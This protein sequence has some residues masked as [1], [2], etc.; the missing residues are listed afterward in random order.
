MK[1]EPFE[2]RGTV[3]EIIESPIPAQAL[4]L[5][6]EHGRALKQAPAPKQPPEQAP[7]SKQ[8]P[9]PKQATASRQGSVPKKA[10]VQVIPRQV[11]SSRA[12]FVPKDGDSLP[13]V[14]G[15]VPSDGCLPRFSHVARCSSAAAT[16][17]S[18][19]SNVSTSS[20][21]TTARSSDEDFAP[22]LL[23]AAPDR[24]SAT[25]KGAETPQQKTQKCKEVRMNKTLKCT[26][27][28]GRVEVDRA[29]FFSNFF[30]PSTKTK[31]KP[32]PDAISALFARVTEML[33]SHCALQM[34]DFRG[35]ENQATIRAY[36]DA[37]F[38]K[39]YVLVGKFTDEPLSFEVRG[40][41][42]PIDHVRGCATGIKRLWAGQMR[43]AKV[44]EAENNKPQKMMCRDRLA[45]RESYLE[46]NNMD[47]AGTRAMY[48]N[49]RSEYLRRNDR[50]A[51]ELIALDIIR[52]ELKVSDPFDNFVAKVTLFPAEAIFC[53]PRQLAVFLRL[54]A[55]PLR[56]SRPLIVGIDSTTQVGRRYES[57][58]EKSKPIPS[59][60]Y[61]AAVS[62][63]MMNTASNEVV[64]LVESLVLHED[65]TTVNGFLSFWL[66]RLKSTASS[67]KGKLPPTL[68]D[69]IVSDK[70]LSTLYAVSN[71]FN[72]MQLFQYVNKVYEAIRGDQGAASFVKRRL[73]LVKIC[74]AHSAHAWKRY[75]YRVLPT[76]SKSHRTVLRHMFRLVTGCTNYQFFLSVVLL[77][78]LI[79][80]NSSHRTKLM[81]TAL[82]TLVSN[83]DTMAVFEEAHDHLPPQLAVET[84]VEL[85]EVDVN[86]LNNADQQ[87][88]YKRSAF[89]ADFIKVNEVV[90]EMVNAAEE[91]EA[92]QRCETNPF[93][94]RDVVNYWL[95]VQAQYLPLITAIDWTIKFSDVPPKRVNNQF[96]EAGFAE[97]KTFIREHDGLRLGN[98][99]DR[100][101]LKT[102]E[103]TKAQLKL[104]DFGDQ[105]TLPMRPKK[106]R[107][108]AEKRLS[109]ISLWKAK[110]KPKIRGWRNAEY[111][112]AA[113]A[114]KLER[115][116][117]KPKKGQP[118]C[119]TQSQPTNVSQCQP[120]N[121]SQCQPPSQSLTL[122][123]NGVVADPHY[124]VRSL[125]TMNFYV[126]VFINRLSVTGE[127]F[128]DLR[129]IQYYLW[130][131]TVY[132]LI[133]ILVQQNRRNDVQVL[134]PSTAAA[135]FFD[136]KRTQR[137]LAAGSRDYQIDKQKSLILAPVTRNEHH[138]LVVIDTV[139]NVFYIV[140]SNASKSK[141][142]TDQQ[143]HFTA[144]VNFLQLQRIVITNDWTLPIAENMRQKDATSC[145]V[146]V[147]EHAKQILETGSTFIN[148]E[149]SATQGRLYY[150]HLLLE[151]SDNMTDRCMICM[152]DAS[153]G[154]QRCKL[155]QRFSHLACLV[156]PQRAEYCELCLLYQNR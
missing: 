120:T 155:C 58:N 93:F 24:S 88:L 46:Q 100:V 113:A 83:C 87:P 92:T 71:N 104:I 22:H 17:T 56:R 144:W 117:T 110:T 15:S 51:D 25:A 62:V 115:S 21:C 147:V 34:K 139:A 121:A 98:R 78:M 43:R 116:S 84:V 12:A 65:T 38:C 135:I 50:D 27:V 1:T 86:A 5:A 74:F 150:A 125:K 131:D 28:M 108:S 55:S 124:Y 40:S 156:Q 72:K 80:F 152:G 20:S 73:T 94:S 45:A 102:S 39:S 97:V 111:L 33:P 82:D 154:I 36:C 137:M 99:I 59:K 23:V 136:P 142:I 105:D 151:S 32:G 53:S 8:A 47:G 52:K 138:Y 133:Q 106:R 130:S 35:T 143:E 79:V 149:F 91:D 148:P 114:K 11:V 3:I 118:T 49:I 67:A 57:D 26:L 128:C 153:E 13:L 2:V 18:D 44:E 145:G 75:H 85:P 4:V 127:H 63:P 37:K 19:E 29:F 96:I 140:D 7:A 68:A 89:H 69:I 10:V 134:L 31:K 129:D 60:F 103:V 14:R 41:A 9:A 123:E 109:D 16:Q 119:A 141:T 64:P 30:D 81:S 77:N 122:Y 54:S 95:V 107:K 112:K 126:P 90:E 48:Q 101:I 66:Q 132:I 6:S 70:A 76:L 61:R 42:N 146:F